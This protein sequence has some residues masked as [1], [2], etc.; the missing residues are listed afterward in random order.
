MKNTLKIPAITKDLIQQSESWLIVTDLDG[1]LLDHFNYSHAAADKMLGVLEGRGIPVIFNSSKTATE[2]VQLKKELNNPHPFIVENG[3]AIYIPHHY[4][5]KE[6]QTSHK[7]TI[8]NIDGKEFL[9]ITL[10][11]ER[12]QLLD[13]LNHDI[14]KFGAPF[15]SFTKAGDDELIAATSLSIEQIQRSRQR[16]FSE[17]LLWQGN[18]TEKMA[19]TQRAQQAG[20]NTLQ[21]GRFLHL[22]GPCNKGKASEV[23]AAIFNETSQKNTDAQNHERWPIIASGDS[24]NDIDML[25]AADIAIVIR[26][27]THELISIH[28]HRH[29]ITSNLFGPEGW[30][31]TIGHLLN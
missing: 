1:T 31:E 28:N 10:G 19:F 6:F 21:G 8:Q 27:P 3:S 15:I 18:L 5:S 16:Y 22:L 26:S 11:S 30:G 25:K 23:L 14:E 9:V 13:F 12:Q 17:P 20:F 7:T 24:D 4:F 2:M 29:V